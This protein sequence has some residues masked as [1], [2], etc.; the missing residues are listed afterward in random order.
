M[1]SWSIE[2]GGVM[3]LESQSGLGCVR[4]SMMRVGNIVDRT[5]VVLDIGN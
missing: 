4:R 2:K 1:V 3:R 5:L